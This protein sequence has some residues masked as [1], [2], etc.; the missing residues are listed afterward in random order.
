MFAFQAEPKNTL[1]PAGKLWASFLR[2]SLDLEL[3]TSLLAVTPC[4][5]P[6]VQFVTTA[7]AEPVARVP[8]VEVVKEKEGLYL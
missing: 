8:E 7:L 1:L 2:W 6:G 5:F 3:N 4:L